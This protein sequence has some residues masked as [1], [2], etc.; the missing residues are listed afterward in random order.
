MVTPVSVNKTHLRRSRPLNTS[1]KSTDSG[2][3]E[4]FLLPLCTAKARR[5]GVFLFTDTGV[6]ENIA[7]RKMLIRATALAA[8]ARDFAKPPAA[9]ARRGLHVVQRELRPQIY[10]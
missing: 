5:K 3:A 8:R 6:S 9:A 2:A 10:T 7:A 1:L 4:E